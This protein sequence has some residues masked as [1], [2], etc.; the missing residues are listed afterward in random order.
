MILAR[1]TFEYQHK[2]I[3]E[4]VTFKT[5]FKHEGIFQNE[6]C[7]VY[8]KEAGAKLLSSEDNMELKN[9]EAVL[10]KC[11]T[12]FLDILKDTEKDKVEVIAVHLYPDIL[13]KLYL[14]ELPALIKKRNFTKE[15][16]VIPSTGIITKFIESLEFYFENPIL[17][18]EDLLELKIK[19][20]ILLLI[21]SKNVESIFELITDLYSAKTIDLK[22]VIALHLFSNL[23]IDELAKLSNLSLSSFKR[24]FK[25]EFND[26]PKNYI[27]SKK[28][29]KAKELLQVSEMHIN[30]IAYEVG[31]NDPLYFTRLFKKRV[32]TSPSA[33][34]SGYL[35]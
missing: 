23:S 32:G 35:S 14:K 17:V 7:F 33:Y 24:E 5:P 27:I 29:E 26:S 28:I 16:R 8:F 19:E 10:L 25:K 34:R 18:N 1:Q 4:K 20:L 21:Q 13:K 11:G 22:E 31:F 12:Y 9:K 3:I 2:T 15:S 6:G 30:E